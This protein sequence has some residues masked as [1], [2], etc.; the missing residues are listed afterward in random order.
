MHNNKIGIVRQLPT[1]DST[2]AASQI[3]I[4]YNSGMVEVGLLFVKLGD[5]EYIYLAVGI[6]FLS[7]SVPEIQLLPV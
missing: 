3:G 6:S 2:M 4:S 5:L 7:V 1:P